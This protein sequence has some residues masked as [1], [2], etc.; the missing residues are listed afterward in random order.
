MCITDTRGAVRA[1]GFRG[2]RRSV[3]ATA[4]TLPGVQKRPGVYITYPCSNFVRILDPSFEYYILS[5][6]TIDF[7]VYIYIYI[8]VQGEARNLGGLGV[9]RTEIAG[10]IV[11]SI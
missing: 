5:N 7:R 11:C 3:Y 2:V 4:L 8:Y 6:A 9:D 1:N 10:V